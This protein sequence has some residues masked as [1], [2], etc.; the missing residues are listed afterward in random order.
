MPGHAYFF[1]IKHFIDTHYI[2]GQLFFEYRKGSCE[3][4]SEGKITSKL[5][6]DSIYFLFS[7]PF[8]LHYSVFQKERLEL[9]STCPS[10]K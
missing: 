5:T 10:Q 6:E 8:L 9:L 2:I 1:K 7:L 3:T 4:S